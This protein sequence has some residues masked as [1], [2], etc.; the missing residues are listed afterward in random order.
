[1]SA[2]QG[3]REGAWWV[4]SV[5]GVGGGEEGRGGQFHVNLSLQ[6]VGASLDLLITREI[7]DCCIE[8][9]ELVVL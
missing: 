9:V 6:R 5:V 1:M 7:Q 2:M 4:S 8:T 3:G